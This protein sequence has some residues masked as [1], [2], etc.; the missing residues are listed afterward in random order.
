MQAGM[1]DPRR[2]PSERADGPA[3]E[4]AARDD[5]GRG[6]AAEAPCRERCDQRGVARVSAPRRLAAFPSPW[7]GTRRGEG[8]ESALEPSEASL[9]SARATMT[10][11]RRRACHGD[12]VEPGLQARASSALA[13][14]GFPGM[15]P[16][17]LA[18][19]DDRFAA[20]LRRGWR[21][22]RAAAR[23][24]SGRARCR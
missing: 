15:S 16:R 7:T 1:T 17:Y 3:S 8:C 19:C 13:W 9:G 6:H 21:S 23:P 12:G 24:I 22:R 5:S 11:G 4:G 10:I 18:S 20:S 2:H 14:F